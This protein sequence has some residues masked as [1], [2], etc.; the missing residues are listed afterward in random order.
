MTV[1]DPDAGPDQDSPGQ[2]GYP[3]GFHPRLVGLRESAGV[4]EPEE[5]VREPAGEHHVQGPERFVLE[6]AIVPPF[7]P[8]GFEIPPNE[9]AWPAWW[10]R[11]M[12]G[13]FEQ[14]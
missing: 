13:Q 6:T 4:P 3:S 8:D 11:T 12:R 9:G 1:R 7:G 14:T 5:R 10:T 2:P